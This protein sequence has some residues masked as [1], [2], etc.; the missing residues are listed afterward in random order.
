MKKILLVVFLL[1]PLFSYSQQEMRMEDKI[2]I[3]EALK[4][5]E[6]V[7]D[8]IWKDWSKADFTILFLSDSLEYLINHPNPS[9]DFTQSYFDTY[10]NKKV[11]IRKKVF[12][13]NFLATF[14][15]VNGVNTVVVGTPENTGRSSLY[16]VI[17]LLH[18]HFHQ[19]QFGQKNYFEK[20]NNLDLS[21]GDN[22]GMWVLSYNFAYE[23]TTV[24]KAFN[25]LKLKLL[26]AF[27]EEDKKLFRKKTIE[28]LKA[29]KEFKNLVSEK[30]YRYLE[31]QLWQEG[32]AR[33]T[34]Y[35]V[36]SYMIKNKYV[37][38]EDFMKLKDYEPL[39][40]NYDKR[41]GKLKDEIK[42]ASLSEEKRVCFYSLGAIEGLVL[43]SYQKHWR[44]KYTKNMFNTSNLFIFK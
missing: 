22:S 28:Y 39:E 36:L 19:Y 17:T 33:Y 41:I 14:P 18:E 21:G 42:K 15:A 7:S 10:L 20:L 35:A 40:E 3:A 30:D 23:D 44:N 31:F 34:E 5:S 12:Q 16:W 2:R 32:I 29:K 13:K 24:N 11:Y 26:D 25:E 43:D 1:L 27:N 4:I 38:S 6:F 37:L 9:E 8:N